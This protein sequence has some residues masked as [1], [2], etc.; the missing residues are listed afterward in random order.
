MMRD[1]GLFTEK[2][3]EKALTETILSLTVP[4]SVQ[5][6]T[7]PI[8]ILLGG[9]SGAGKTTLHGILKE[10]YGHN[11]IVI[12]GDEYRSAHPHFAELDERYGIDSVEHTARWASAMAEALIDRLSA[13]GYNLIVEGTLRT[14]E[15]PLKTARFLRE[16][17]YAVSI[18]IM[19]VK[20]EISLVSCQ[21]RYEMMRLSGTTP[22]ATDPAYHDK[23]VHDIVDNL[24]VLEA[25]GLFD[26]I[27]LYDRFERCLFPNGG[28]ENCASEALRS[29]LF[30]VWSEEELGHLKN[31]K[32][33]LEN[34]Q[35]S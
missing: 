3:L 12:N 7:F 8:G 27:Y 28:S 11:V 18:A 19:A 20:P 31:L 16:R 22:R 6:V 10:Q 15:V 2:E 14:S 29:A 32:E 13:A 25:S 21:I 23:I 35:S 24:A 5:S 33:K 34:L 30:G 17:G 26:G 9:Q 4:F 1:I